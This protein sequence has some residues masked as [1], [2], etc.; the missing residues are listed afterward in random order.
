MENIHIRIQILKW[1]ISYL[2]FIEEAIYYGILLEDNDEHTF[3]LLLGLRRILN[4]D[5]GSLF[6]GMKYSEIKFFRTPVCLFFRE[7]KTD[8]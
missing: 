4:T 1:K 7:K 3:E 6:E 5:I 8:R 2:M